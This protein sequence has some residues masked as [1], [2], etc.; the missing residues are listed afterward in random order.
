M[1]TSNLCLRAAAPLRAGRLPARDYYYTVWTLLRKFVSPTSGAAGQFACR[2]LPETGTRSACAYVVSVRPFCALVSSAAPH[3]YAPVLRALRRCSY[4]TLPALLVLLRFGPSA[5]PF[6]SV[7]HTIP[8]GIPAAGDRTG[9]VLNAAGLLCKFSISLLS[10]GIVA[11]LAR[12]PCRR[13][14]VPSGTTSFCLLWYVHL[15]GM[16]AG[17]PGGGRAAC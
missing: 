6:A 15:G 13:R 16:A 14:A 9:Y 11:A 1:A 10:R 8:N 3:L 17:A 12:A 5:W 7:W 4:R 2:R